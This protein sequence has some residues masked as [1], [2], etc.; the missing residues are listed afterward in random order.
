ME[1]GDGNKGLRSSTEVEVVAKGERR[2]FTAQYK[3]KV[4]RTGELDEVFGL[5]S[6]GGCGIETHL[7]PI[8][9]KL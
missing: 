4:V 7:N 6:R 8:R 3:L 9:I 1:G 5:A 2:P